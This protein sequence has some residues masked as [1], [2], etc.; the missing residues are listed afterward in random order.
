V[1]RSLTNWQA[2]YGAFT[3]SHAGRAAVMAY[4]MNQEEHHHPETF[5]EKFKRLLKEEGI[6]FEERY[7]S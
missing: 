1:F 5:I 4:I 7:L 2:E 3:K 6:S